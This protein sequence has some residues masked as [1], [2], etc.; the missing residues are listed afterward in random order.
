MRPPASRISGPNVR[1]YCPG[2][3]AA[4]KFRCSVVLLVQLKPVTVGFRLPA[5]PVKLSRSADGSKLDVSIGWLKVRSTD[6]TGPA[7]AAVGV[8]AR[9]CVVGVLPLSVIL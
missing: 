5:G 8:L 6:A 9:T 4:A 3:V 1:E 7:T 2:T